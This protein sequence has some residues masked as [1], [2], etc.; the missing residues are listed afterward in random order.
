MKEIL[1][2]TLFLTSALNTTAAMSSDNS[3]D[4]VTEHNISLPYALKLAQAAMDTCN[5]LGE[6]VSVAVLDNKGSV[7]AQLTADGAFL[8]SV[9]A[10]RSKAY[11]SLSRQI[12]THLIQEHVKANSDYNTAINFASLGMSTWGGGLP[13][14]HSGQVIGAIGVSGAPTGTPDVACAETAL[15]SIQ[16]N[17]E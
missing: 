10:S 17:Q 16:I 7:K 11:A 8:H 15:K 3:I 5:K 14:K 9:E 6:K 2:S 12:P 1:L 13:I 4:I